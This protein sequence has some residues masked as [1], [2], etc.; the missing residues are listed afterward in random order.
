MMAYIRSQNV[1]HRYIFITLISAYRSWWWFIL[2]VLIFS[3]SISF[4]KINTPKINQNTALAK[5]STGEDQFR[6]WS[7]LLTLSRRRSYHIETSQMICAAKQWTDFYMIGTTVT[8]EL[9]H[10]RPMFQ[11]MK[12]PGKSQADI[13]KGYWKETLKR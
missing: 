13:F 8:K 11:A 3:N 5:L 6:L 2:T 9:I 7:V 12:T 1:C 10:F 4:M